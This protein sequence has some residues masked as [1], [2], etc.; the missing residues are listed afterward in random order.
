MRSAMISLMIYIIIDDMVTGNH[1]TEIVKKEIDDEISS[2]MGILHEYA[3][4]RLIP[5]EENAWKDSV[6]ERIKN[7]DES[8]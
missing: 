1:K 8:F 6:S 4:P 5:Y 7:G 3:D 2:V